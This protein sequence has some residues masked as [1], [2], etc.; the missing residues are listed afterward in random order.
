MVS[1]AGTESTLAAIEMLC[2]ST[3]YTFAAS[4]APTIYST[5][6]KII[7]H[8]LIF[9]A[10]TLRNR[11]HLLLPVLKALLTC[12]FT[13]R[14]NSK[15]PRDLRPPSWIEQMPA[16]VMEHRPRMARL[17][18]RL[19]V[20]WTQPTVL[21]ATARPMRTDSHLIDQSRIMRE[22]VAVFVPEVLAHFCRMQLV[23]TPAPDVRPYL[24]PALWA[25][26]MA[27][28]MERLRAMNADLGRDERAIWRSLW[29]E[30]RR[31]QGLPVS[32]ETW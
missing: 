4:Q 14:P 3:R 24:M 28:P 23:G 15:P 25:C 11:A 21:A 9:Y 1:R 8:F 29:V 31:A 6:C 16:G 19:L 10:E 13:I 12:H 26:I 20:H 17:F 32:N 18:T 7:R 30:Y 5:L 2:T 27:V 22:R